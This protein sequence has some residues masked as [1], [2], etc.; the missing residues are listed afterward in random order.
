MISKSRFDFEISAWDRLKRLQLRAFKNY[1]T[2]LCK[3]NAIAIKL[4]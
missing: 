3:Y 2:Q 1:Y 4:E